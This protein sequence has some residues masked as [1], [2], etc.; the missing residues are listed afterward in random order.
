MN[1][2]GHNKTTKPYHTRKKVKMKKII[3]VV[4]FLHQFQQKNTS[5][6]TIYLGHLWYD[7]PPSS[8]CLDLEK[9]RPFDFLFFV[10]SRL[11]P[12]ISVRINDELFRHY[13]VRRQL[14]I[15][16]GLSRQYHNT[17]LL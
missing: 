4:R 16:Q 11:D 8:R 15:F 9:K 17:S 3:R 12:G 2:F 6:K 1:P 5:F 14:P 13:S 10:H 7:P